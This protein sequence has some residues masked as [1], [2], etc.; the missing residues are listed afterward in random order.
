[1]TAQ[2]ANVERGFR[3]LP[4]MWTHR[5]SSE[6]VQLLREAILSL[7]IVCKSGVKEGSLSEEKVNNY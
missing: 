1:M 4:W 3:G 7:K 5:M 2:P 6:A